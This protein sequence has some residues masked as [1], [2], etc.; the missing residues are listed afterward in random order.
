MKI[1]SSFIFVA[2]SLFSQSAIS[3]NIFAS[4]SIVQI[5]EPKP[6]NDLSMDTLLSFRQAIEKT[7]KT[8]ATLPF[9]IDFQISKMPGLSSAQVIFRG[10]TN[11]CSIHIE[12]QKVFDFWPH[13]TPFERDLSLLFV[14]LHESGHCHLY[15]KTPFSWN[16][17]EQSYLFNSFIELDAWLPPDERSSWFAQTHEQ[18]ADLFAINHLIELGYS[19]EDLQFIQNTRGKLALNSSHHSKESFIDKYFQKI[20]S[21]Q[22]F[23]ER[24]L[25]ANSM[26]TDELFKDPSFSVISNMTT[27]QRKYSLAQQLSDLYLNMWFPET[28]K[29]PESIEII[30]KHL[31]WLGTSPHKSKAI[32]FSLLKNWFFSPPEQLFN[33]NFENLNREQKLILIKKYSTAFVNNLIK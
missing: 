21:T 13:N 18:F 25:I 17:P 4:S 2:V 3:Q 6:S 7:N 12:P 30:S 8:N 28:N 19:I 10:E 24:M 32:P 27:E 9:D 26:I 16:I 1:L 31:G 5:P 23:S 20:T 33:N 22:S 15:S 14:L 29:A 11:Q